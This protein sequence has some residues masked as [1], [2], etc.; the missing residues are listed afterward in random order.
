M[1]CNISTAL[2]IIPYVRLE[3]S[4]MLKEFKAKTQRACWKLL[5]FSHSVTKL[6]SNVTLMRA[7]IENGTGA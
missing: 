1:E 5:L 7:I 3:P 2:Y 6:Q 4:L